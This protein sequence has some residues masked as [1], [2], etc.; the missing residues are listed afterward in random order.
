MPSRLRAA[1]DQHL[2][3]V[4]NHFDAVKIGLTATPAAHTVSIFGEPVFRYGDER[5][6]LE[7]YLVDKDTL[8]RLVRPAPSQFHFLPFVRAS[9]LF[10]YAK[11]IRQKQAHDDFS[12]NSTFE[13]VVVSGRN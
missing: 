2:A 10:I 3:D 7:G 5:A 1:V 4:I 8:Q 6:I 12:A 9:P 13:A 11:R